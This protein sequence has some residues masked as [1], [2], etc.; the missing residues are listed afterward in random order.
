MAS[1]GS[2]SSRSLQDTPTWALAAVCFVFIFLSLFIEHLIHLISKWLKKHRKTALFEAVEKLKSVL[3]LLGFMSLILTV[4]QRSI[5]KICIPTKVAFTMLP[6]RKNAPT[7]TTKALGLEQIPIE[8][9]LAA[10]DTSEDHCESQGKTSFISEGGLNQLNNF[11]F[12]LAVMQIVYSVL[13]MA[14][15][16]AKMRRWEAWEK[17]TQTVEYQVANDPNRFRFTRQTT[18]A[19][20]HMSSCTGRG[21]TA[22]LWIT[23]LSTNH[24]AF[25]F[26]K[27]IQ[28]S[29]DDDFRTVVGISPLLWFIVVI[30][31]LLDVHGWQVYLMVSFVPLIIVLVLGTKLEVVVANMAHQLHDQH[32]VI[33]GTPLV[34]PKDSH[35]WFSQPQFVLTLLHLT[36]FMNAFELAFFIWVT[37]QF[38]IHSCYHEHV[39]IIIV[40]VVLAV[41]VQV[42]CSYITL[43]LYALVTQMGSNFKSAAVLEEQTTNVIKQWHADVKRRR[44]NKSHYSQSGHDENS[45]RI[46]NSPDFSSHRPQLTFADM[47]QSH[48][49]ET[50]NFHDNQEIVE[51]H[52]EGAG[53]NEIEL[54][55]NA[56][57]TEVPIGMPEVTRT[58]T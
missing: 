45:S 46:M 10:A 19:L 36:L 11:I 51:D 12:I 6:C 3:I 8:R 47:N 49:R 50:E 14:L 9:M 48:P 53:Q 24:N 5:S 4:S 56:S 43:P 13:T 32:N 22:Q 57:S 52:Q 35:F 33:K 39:Y 18:F 31:I 44:E 15:G 23:H 26:Q 37:I 42:M 7:K 29:L 16:R 54:A 34:Q 41:T 1:A 38:G 2:A 27:Y 20:R 25:D 58:H 55:S 30:F 40:R 17:E 21:T 28:R